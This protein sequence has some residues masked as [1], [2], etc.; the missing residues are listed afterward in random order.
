MPIAA[1]E[2]AQ[3]LEELYGS[4]LRRTTNGFA[5]QMR[6]YGEYLAAEALENDEVGK[7][8]ELAFVDYD[9]PNESWMNCVSYLAELNA[10]VR[11]LF[12]RRYPLWMLGSSPTAFSED[13]KDQIVR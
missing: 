1:R 8:R 4:I 2:A 9:T 10:G 5:F 12:V 7:L 11:R 3:L 6:S 13:E